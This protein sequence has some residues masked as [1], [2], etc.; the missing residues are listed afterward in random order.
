[1]RTKIHKQKREIWSKKTRPKINLALI[2]KTIKQKNPIQKKT[3][4]NKTKKN[5]KF[6]PLPFL[7]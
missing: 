2:G 6:T 7:A 4:K 1:M 5:K 3:V